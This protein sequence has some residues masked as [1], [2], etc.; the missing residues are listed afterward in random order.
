MKQI[1]MT[2]RTKALFIPGFLFVMFLTTN[3]WAQTRQ[4]TGVITDATDPL[5]GA[6]V[7]VK[8]TNTGTISGVD[9]SFTIQ[10]GPDATLVVS[11]I[12]YRT[13]EVG[14]NNRQY[15]RRAK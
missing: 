7:T 8:G 15:V 12:G 5:P 1:D 2:R 11:F 10:A 6:S 9:G 3:V 13:L 14:L 4:V